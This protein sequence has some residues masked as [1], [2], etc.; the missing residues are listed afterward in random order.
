MLQRFKNLQF[1]N[2]KPEF[3][4]LEL[5]SFGNQRV[6]LKM[7]IHSIHLN[8]DNGLFG[9]ITA[10]LIDIGGSLAIANHFDSPITGVSTNL[11]VNFIRAAKLGDVVTVDAQ[12]DKVGKNLAFTSISLFV[13]DKLIANGTHTKYVGAITKDYSK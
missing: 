5:V 2:S 3:K 10:S 6:L 7:P 9:G 8:K 4:H 13:D 11:Q 12:C 1:L